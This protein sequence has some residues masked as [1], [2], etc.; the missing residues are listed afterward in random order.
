MSDYISRNIKSEETWKVTDACYLDLNLVSYT[1][2]ELMEN[3]RNDVKLLTIINFLKGD[4]KEDIDKQYRKQ[5]NRFVLQNN[6]L[7]YNFH[8]K[9]L[10]LVPNEMRTE[11]IR[12]AHERFYSGH[13][14]EFKTYHR[15]LDTV[16]WP[17]MMDGIRDY[18]RNCKA[19]VLTKR[20]QRKSRLGKRLFPTQPNELIS[21]DYIVDF[22]GHVVISTY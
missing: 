22:P 16:W 19:C 4:L 17:N 21:I 1:E 7:K 3:Q 11:I 9:C 20:K 15:L 18:I 8:G 6:L 5:K 13:F 12:Y 2:D 10:L 14:G